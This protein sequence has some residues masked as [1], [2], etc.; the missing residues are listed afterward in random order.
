MRGEKA[1]GAGGE[2][3]DAVGEGDG[4]RNIVRDE[5][6]R[7]LLASEDVRNVRGDFEAGLI[8]ERGE[9]L[10]EEQDVG[11]HD[12]RSDERGALAHPARELGRIALQKARKP[13]FFG[14]FH[15]AGA[16]VGGVLFL[17]FEGKVQIFLDGAPREEFVALEHVA[18]APF[19]RH[20]ARGGL[21]NARRERKDGALAAA[22]RADHGGKFPLAEGEGEPV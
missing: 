7:F 1:G 13:V 11:L 2:H 22:R 17:H 8:V 3:E 15:R 4:L 12:E 20:L 14:E 9:G 16:A 21:Q 18:D 5:E 6:R 10:V 19:A